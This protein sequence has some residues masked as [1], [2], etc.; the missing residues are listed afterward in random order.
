MQPLPEEKRKCE[1]CNIRAPVHYALKGYHKFGN[2]VTKDISEDGMGVVL[3]QFVA[4]ATDIFLELN[5]SSRV[6]SALG[7][8]MWV[9]QLPS[10]YR[11]RAGIK[12]SDLDDLEQKELS[13]YLNSYQAKL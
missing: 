10:S 6:V 4:P 5:I 11:Y 3:D 8:V 12:F 1:R 2:T 7:K 13:Q 9:Q